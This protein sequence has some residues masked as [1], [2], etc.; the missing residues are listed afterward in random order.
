[1]TPG[2]TPKPNCVLHEHVS[3][4]LEGAGAGAG[5]GDG[6]PT[7]AAGDGMSRAATNTSAR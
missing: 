7:P 2:I 1:M 4:A 3:G 6:E 5:A